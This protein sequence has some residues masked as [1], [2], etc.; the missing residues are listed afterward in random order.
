MEFVK[1]I[2]FILWIPLILTIVFFTTVVD[3]SDTIKVRKP[4]LEKYYKR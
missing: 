4:A 1:S 3:K 2:L